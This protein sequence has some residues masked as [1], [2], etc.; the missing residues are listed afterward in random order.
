M[1]ADR[2]PLRGFYEREN[3]KIIRTEESHMTAATG[4]T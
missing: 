3:N 2:K 4:N 1:S